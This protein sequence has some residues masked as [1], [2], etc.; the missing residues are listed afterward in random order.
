[1]SSKTLVPSIFLRDNRQHTCLIFCAWPLGYFPSSHQIVTRAPALA[2]GQRSLNQEV[3]SSSVALLKFR[4]LPHKKLQLSF[5]YVL[6]EIVEHIFV[7]TIIRGQ[8]ENEPKF[9]PEAYT[10][11]V[12]GEHSVGIRA[13]LPS[14]SIG[15][16]TPGSFCSGPE[17]RTHPISRV[18]P[19]SRY[20][21]SQVSQGW[22]FHYRVVDYGVP[23]TRETEE[24]CVVEPLQQ[25]CEFE[26]PACLWITQHQREKAKMSGE[27]IPESV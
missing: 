8:N 23:C 13:L 3:I 15:N 4:E 16:Q 6:A 14:N 26:G 19:V 24:I 18:S 2:S 20:T 7:K 1:M 9:S 10:H 22:S 5:I 25:P 11:S 27:K 17:E 12:D 21:G